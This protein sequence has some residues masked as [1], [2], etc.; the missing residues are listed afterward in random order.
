MT[1]I[2][3][4]ENVEGMSVG[5]ILAIVL[6]STAGLIGLTLILLCICKRAARAKKFVNVKPHDAP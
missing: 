1:D 4:N 3:V 5:I 2:A 6:P